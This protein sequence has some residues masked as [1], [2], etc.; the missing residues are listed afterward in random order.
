MMPVYAL[1]SWIAAKVSAPEA[2]DHF[3]AAGF[4][5][6]ELSDDA[7]ALVQAWEKNPAGVARQLAEAGLQAVSVHCP[8]AGQKL[9]VPDEEARYA[10]LRALQHYL[11]LMAD[12]AVP[13]MIVH[14]IS[15]ALTPD[16]RGLR[17][18]KQRIRASLETL[19]EAA[20]SCGLRLCLE[21]LGS[22]SALGASIASLLEMIEGL[23]EH[24]GICHDIGHTVQAGLDVVEEVRLALRSGKLFALHLHDVNEARRDHFIPGE[25]CL[26][27]QPYLAELQAY[28]FSGVRTLEIAPATEPLPE[29]LAQIARVRRQ[30]EALG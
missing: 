30:W 29:R 5:Q 23:G 10:S 25:G 11:R 21:N 7:S 26:N 18:T 15:G 20:V 24:V 17:E 9:D 12:S 28:A 8:G 19:A 3:A 14:P 1:S 16:E 2:I 13:L 6:L 4:T 22:N 27:F